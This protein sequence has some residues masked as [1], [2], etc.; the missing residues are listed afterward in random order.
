M[1]PFLLLSICRYGLYAEQISVEIPDSPTDF[2]DGLFTMCG[3]GSSFLR[4]GY[5]IH[6]YTANKSMEN[7]AFCNADGDFLVVPHK[8][9]R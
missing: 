2:I 8:G 6:M 4:D 7:S 5:D 9:N 1:K 3:A